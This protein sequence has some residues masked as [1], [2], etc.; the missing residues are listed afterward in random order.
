MSVIP[1][2]VVHEHRDI[3]AGL[4]LEI[5]AVVGRTSIRARDMTVVA[6]P[7]ANYGVSVFELLLL[8]R[9]GSSLV[10]CVSAGPVFDDFAARVSRTSAPSLKSITTIEGP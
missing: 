3:V 4:S 1:L 8:S 9:G 5:A 10:T 6:H 7:V 2:E